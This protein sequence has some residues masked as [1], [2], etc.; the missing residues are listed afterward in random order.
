[1]KVIEKL[2]QAKETRGA[3]YFVLI[4][5]DKQDIPRAVKMA[6]KCEKAD[7]DAL[8]VGGSLLFAHYFDEL[9][10]AIKA[11]CA[12]PVII[13][14]GGT[15]QISPFADAILFISL[16]SGRNPNTLIGEQVTSAPI[17]KAMGLEAISTAYM[18]IE[19]GNITT[20]QFMSDTRPIPREKPDIA[21]AHVLAAE[22][23]GMKFA[24]LEAGSGAKHS[25][26]DSLISTLQEYVTIPLI[27][28]GGIR[29]PEEARNK[30][31]AGASFIVTG[32]VLEKNNDSEFIKAFAQAVHIKD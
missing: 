23:L 27:V 20:A 11:E 30:V 14:P 2:F 7:V 1:M 13:F 22:Y 25:V 5:P 24:Y 4:D 15:R 31:L 29:T 21:I 26:P 12:L 18:F 19:S 10:Q 16:I 8:L 17:I 32:N 6:K 3:G 9:I 28:G